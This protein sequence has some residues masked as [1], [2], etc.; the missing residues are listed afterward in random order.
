[1]GW[2]CLLEALG[3]IQQI[4]IRWSWWHLSADSLGLS[5]PPQD[6]LVIGLTDGCLVCMN[7]PVGNSERL[8]CGCKLCAKW[9]AQCCYVPGYEHAHRYPMWSDQRRF[10]CDGLSWMEKLRSEKKE[11][12]PAHVGSETAWA[13]WESALNC[14]AGGKRSYQDPWFVHSFLSP[15]WS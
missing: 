3:R 9:E 7:E 1:M 10:T 14:L 11:K 8:L 6:V 4:S 12:A 15:I 13:T 5:V 2:Y